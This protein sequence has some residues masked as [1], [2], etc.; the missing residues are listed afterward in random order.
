M[1]S[2]LD[3]HASFPTLENDGLVPVNGGAEEF[4]PLHLHKGAKFRVEI[5]Q[6]VVALVGAFYC[7]MAAR[8]GDVIRDPDIRFLPPPNLQ[9]CLI[10]CVY[11]VEHLL[12]D[13]GCVNAL[14]HDE[15]SLWLINIHDV[16]Y[17]V[18]VRN[19]EWEH[20]FA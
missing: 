7:R 8:H 10:L 1:L 4:G 12:W 19:L 2:D 13:G 9:V 20:L 6:Y 5:F 14:E 17:A 11:D 18:V 16:H 15:V 3:S